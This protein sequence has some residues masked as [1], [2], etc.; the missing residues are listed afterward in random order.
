VIQIYQIEGMSCSHC[1]QRVQK[2]LALHHDVYEVQVSQDP[3]LATLRLSH[4]V[5]IEDLQSFLSSVGA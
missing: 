1:V 3:P 2:A 4:P 5:K